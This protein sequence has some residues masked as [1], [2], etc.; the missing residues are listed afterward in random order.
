MAPADW[1]T[2]SCGDGP[3]AGESW[4]VWGS[5]AG[6]IRRPAPAGIS[7]IRVLIACAAFSVMANMP[8]HRSDVRAV[9]H[10]GL[11][12]KPPR[13]DRRFHPGAYSP[14]DGG[15]ACKDYY[16]HKGEAMPGC[17]PALSN[18]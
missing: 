10:G 11:P 15:I 6:A 9:V 3:R 2:V 12:T 4:S 5:W 7:E 17:V 1:T 8:P 18:I 13:P 16:Q 14:G